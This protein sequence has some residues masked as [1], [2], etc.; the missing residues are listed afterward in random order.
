MTAAE[1]VRG[2]LGDA[3]P[4]LLDAMLAALPADGTLPVPDAL[5][6]G[7]L[8]LYARLPA[9]GGREDALPLLAADA[10]FTHALEAQAEVDPDGVAA[11]A[12]CVGAAGALAGLAS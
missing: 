1:W 5:A 7:A 6:T 2:R 11:L 9:T 10:L 8:A 12:E 3:P 4:A